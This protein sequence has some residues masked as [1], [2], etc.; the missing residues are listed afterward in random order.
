MNAFWSQ[1]DLGS[2]P[3]STIYFCVIL[4]NLFNS[5]V[6]QLTHLQC[7]HHTGL[8]LTSYMRKYFCSISRG[9]A[10]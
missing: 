1:T 10:Q 8:F 4:G 9:R 6:P 3:S 2:S 5:S 7:I